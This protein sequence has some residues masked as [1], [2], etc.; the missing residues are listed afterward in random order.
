VLAALFVHRG[1]AESKDSDDRMEE[2]IDRIV[3]KLDA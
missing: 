1:S 3:K 2:K